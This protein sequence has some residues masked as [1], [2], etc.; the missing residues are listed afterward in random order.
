MTKTIAF[1]NYKGGVAK[2]TTTVNM[3]AIIAKTGK[4]VLIV[5]IDPQGSATASLFSAETKIAA[6]AYDLIF[7]EAQSEELAKKCLYE[8]NK[9][10]YVMP[11]DD[12]LRSGAV[13]LP[14]MSLREFSLKRGLEPIK[15]YFD[16]ILID[17]PPS[18][19]VYADISFACADELIIPVGCDYLAQRGVRQLLTSAIK[20]GLKIN[21]DLAVAGVVFT[22]FRNTLEGKRVVEQTTDMLNELGVR[23]FKSVIPVNTTAAE[24]PRASL[25]LIDFDRTAAATKAYENLVR[26]YLNGTQ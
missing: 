14:T 19:Q 10:L 24:A 25:P 5:D 21:P 4:R 13:M 15:K 12:R 20:D 18:V 8:V 2:T 22:L 3:A 16:Y 9:N 1:I 7:A 11:G 17:A 6:G 26:E 23:A